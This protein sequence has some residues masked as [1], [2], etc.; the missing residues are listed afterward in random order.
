[1]LLFIEPCVD[2]LIYYPDNVTNI[3]V[4]PENKAVCTHDDWE[5]DNW[6]RI[7]K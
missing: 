5:D 7:N 1:M 3:S 2:M 4:T 6:N